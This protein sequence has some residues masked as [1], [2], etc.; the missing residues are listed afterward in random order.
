M[1]PTHEHTNTTEH[2]TKKPAISLPAAILTGAVIIAIAIIVAFGGRTAPTGN[3]PDTDQAGTSPTNV[4]ADIATV[5]DTDYV[6]GNRGG[7]IAV[8]EY[9]DSDCPFCQRFHGVM[10][11]IVTEDPG[12]AWVYRHFP[13]DIHPN[14]YTES[15]A[16]EC[17]GSLGGNA[18]YQSYL[19]G[20]MNVTLSPDPESNKM[21]IDMAVKAGVSKSS[22]EACIQGDKAAARVDA[23][24]AEGQAAGVR[25]T[26]FNIVVNTKT[27]EQVILAGAYP[28]ESVRDAIKSLR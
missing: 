1:E 19:D 16:L 10:N 20:I 6:R 9:S 28:I 15:V 12:V 13:L 23:E 26:P 27:G 3:A 2:T 22:F 24:L 17:V 14:A 4:S 21:L 8:I 18:A 7:D 25:G 5:R 11:Q